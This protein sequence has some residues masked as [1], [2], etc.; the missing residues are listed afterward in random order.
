M[1]LALL[2]LALALPTL[3]A[4]ADDEAGVAR[5]GFKGTQPLP[6]LPAGAFT[7]VIVPDTQDYLG[8]G[9]KISTRAGTNLQEPVTN[10]HLEAQARWIR[11]HVRDQNIVFVSHVGDIVE[12]NRPEEWTVAKQHLDT[13]RGVAPFGLT[14]GNHDMAGSGDAI[15]FQ[16]HFPAVSFKQYPWYLGSY[17]HARADQNVSANNVNSAQIFSAGGMDFLH[18]NLECNAPDDVLAWANNLIARHPERRA[19]ITTHMDLGVLDKPKDPEGFIKDAKGRMRWTK[20]H[21]KLGNTA[22]QMWDKCYRK[23]ANLAMVLC[24][25][26][27]RVTAMRVTDTGDHGNTVHRLL[28]DYQSEPVLRLMR[29]VASENRVHVVSY[30]VKRE[31]L[32]DA[33]D[34]VADRDQ[35]QFTLE[36]D[37]STSVAGSS[38][39]RP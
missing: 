20:I 38:S 14:V 18:L 33:T 5:P 9:T 28:S 6:P 16:M 8:A 17:E 2:W 23:H 4:L 24:G 12:Y 26:Q 13:L 36:Y 22:E 29:F 1:L 19:L 11:E 10:P 31:I 35:H 27:S 21:G 37:M 32:I 34:Y 3:P 7:I 39:T 25:D 15:L 30:E